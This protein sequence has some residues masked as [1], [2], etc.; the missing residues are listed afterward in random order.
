MRIEFPNSELSI[1]IVLKTILK[2]RKRRKRPTASTTPW[3]PAIFR[4]AGRTRSPAPQPNQPRPACLWA[5]AAQQS[6]PLASSSRSCER[7]LCHHDRI[8]DC[9]ISRATSRVTLASRQHLSPQRQTTTPA[10]ESVYRPTGAESPRLT[11]SGRA[12]QPPARRVRA[13]GGTRRG[14]RGGSAPHA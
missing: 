10:Q 7:S 12:G 8:P 6:S 2:K 9:D 1:D 11:T 4:P 5:A 3:T 14:R 13:R